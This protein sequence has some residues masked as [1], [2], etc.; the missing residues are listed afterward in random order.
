MSAP[1][2][3]ESE[4]QYFEQAAMALWDARPK[5]DRRSRFCVKEYA[6]ILAVRVKAVDA[7]LND[8]RNWFCPKEFAKFEKASRADKSAGWL[9]EPLKNCTFCKQ[10]KKPRYQTIAGGKI[11]LLSLC[12]NCYSF[13]AVDS[14][15]RDGAPGPICS[16]CHG[17]LGDAHCVIGDPGLLLCKT[18]VAT[19]S[20]VVLHQFTAPLHDYVIPVRM[21]LIL[22]RKAIGR[23]LTTEEET[24]LP[25]VCDE[26]RDP[27][28]TAASLHPA[29]MLH[30]AF[31]VHQLARAACKYCNHCK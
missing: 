8:V 18:C 16:D 10:V 12:N 13:T 20:A 27:V 24:I 31:Q 17:I 21:Q 15:L 25:L 1:S 26:I 30:L 6:K 23:K 19:T 5:H 3:S 22:A 14:I 28:T 4:L 2:K 7:L 9:S 29:N 11:G